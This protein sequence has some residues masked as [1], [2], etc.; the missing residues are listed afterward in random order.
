MFQYWMQMERLVRL[1]AV[2]VPCTCMTHMS[3]TRPGTLANIMGRMTA[4]LG[5][6]I[7]SSIAVWNLLGVPPD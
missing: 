5:P 7:M 2:I 6:R 4:L 3:V 1:A